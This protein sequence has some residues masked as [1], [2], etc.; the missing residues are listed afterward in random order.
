MSLIYLN[1]SALSN[2]HLFTLFF[3]LFLVYKLD[4]I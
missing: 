1:V 3:F 4:Y 2:P